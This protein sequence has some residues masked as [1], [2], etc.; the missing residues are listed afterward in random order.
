MKTLPTLLFDVYSARLVDGLA[1][2]KYHIALHHS[3]AVKLT[4]RPPPGAPLGYADQRTRWC[5]AWIAAKPGGPL[6]L[7]SLCS[8]C[9]VS[10]ARRPCAALTRALPSA[11][12]ASTAVAPEMI[13]ERFLAEPSRLPCCC[14]RA[15]SEVEET[16]K[17][18]SSHKGVHG[19]LIVNVEGVPIRST[20]DPALVRCER[21]PGHPWRAAAARAGATRRGGSR[22]ARAQAACARRAVPLAAI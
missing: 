17:R 8:L 7:L 22:S 3:R 19:I 20:L 15:Q 13:I 4:F 12:G 1:R 9:L 6:R 14:P 11:R 5:A 18:I 2:G 16:L 21:W 10:H